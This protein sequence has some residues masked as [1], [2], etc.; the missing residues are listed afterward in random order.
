LTIS[1][2]ENAELFWGIR[3]G[4]GNFG[5]VTE[6]VYRLHEQRRTVFC[7]I[8]VFP[9]PL[10]E[11]LVQTSLKWVETRDPDKEAMMQVM[12]RSPD[13]HVSGLLSEFQT[14]SS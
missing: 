3:G 9:G 12:T 2:S 6:F 8:M 7:G 4:G 11:T 10:L 14:E 1:E 13:G 5:I